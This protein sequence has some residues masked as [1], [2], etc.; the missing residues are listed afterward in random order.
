[1]TLSRHWLPIALVCAAHAAALAAL[2]PSMTATGQAAPQTMS[3]VVINTPT[4]ATPQPKQTVVTP[5]VSTPTAEPVPV[6]QP[7]AATEAVAA[8]EPTPADSTPV[9][10]TPVVT[11]PRIDASYRGNV[12][13]AYPPASRRLGEEGVVMLRIFVQTD[14]SVGDV[15]LQKSSGYNRLDQ[16]AIAT[17]KKWKLIPARRGSEPFATWYTLP[18]EFNLEN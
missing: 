14:G 16:V 7:P 12:A 15:T 3:V 11:P 2:L 10:A 18:F 6:P 4:R 1:M 17:V 13:P 5:P 8:A 9:E